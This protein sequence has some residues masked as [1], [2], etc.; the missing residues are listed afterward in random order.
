MIFN[1]FL[2]I[3]LSKFEGDHM[4]MLDKQDQ[5]EE[6]EKKWQAR[7]TGR[8]CCSCADFGQGK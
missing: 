5:L 6:R 3:L 8:A 2:A 4:A 7:R 1:L